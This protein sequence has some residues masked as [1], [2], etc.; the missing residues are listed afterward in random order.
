MG[1]HTIMTSR[2]KAVRRVEAFGFRV[3]FAGVSESAV[4][5]PHR[6]DARWTEQ[7]VVG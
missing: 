6:P 1:A 5:V 4:R 7:D 2:P 3:F